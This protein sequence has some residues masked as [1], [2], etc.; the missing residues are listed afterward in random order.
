[1]YIINLGDSR[2]VILN[3][4]SVLQTSKDHKPTDE[5]EIKRIT[6]LG[7]CIVNKRVN[8]QLGTSRALGNNFLKKY[9]MYNKE[10]S[11][12]DADKY[13]GENCLL[14]P[15]I[16]EY[17]RVGDEI[18]VLASDGIWDRIDNETMLNL[19]YSSINKN[20][21]NNKICEIALETAL[22]RGSIDNITI[23]LVKL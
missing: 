17:N 11:K 3:K 19:I 13:Y 1:M 20:Y 21:D 16:I 7:I 8:G 15:D 18:I 12:E 14:P 4:N 5:S 6:E 22:D 10:C 23:M 9:K 2:T